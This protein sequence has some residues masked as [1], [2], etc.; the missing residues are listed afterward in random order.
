MKR[1]APLTQD[2]GHPEAIDLDAYLRRIGY[3]GGLQPLPAV[4]EALHLAHA[5]HIPFE[6]LDILL[7]RPIRL[8][9][10]SLQGKLVAGGR[11]GYCFEQNLLF[12]AV[13]QRLGFAV[14]RYA[15]RV[16]YPSGRTV[17]RTHIV[18]LVDVEGASWLA[19]VG[20]GLEGLLRPVPFGSGAEARQY[21]RTYRVVEA[22]GEWMLQSLRNG[23]WKDLYAFLLAPQLA[24]DFEPANHYSATHPDSRF[25]RTLTVQLPTPEVCYRL[26]NRELVL[27]RGAGITR[28]V[29]ADDEELL[30]VLAG[31]FG[32]HFPAGTRFAYREDA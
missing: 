24:V 9:L 14:T 32:L 19:D 26:R 6:N 12:S 17:P 11:G 2:A 4:L 28:R 15:A 29:L 8:D 25:V 10:A 31:T 30:A 3:S 1:A 22:N 27:D 16:I 7:G 5:T 21:G 18:L 13:L 23:A 20:F